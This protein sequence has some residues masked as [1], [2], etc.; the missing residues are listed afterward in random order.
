MKGSDAAISQ[1]ADPPL[2]PLIY[3][4]YH[5]T[6]KKFTYTRFR[7]LPIVFLTRPLVPS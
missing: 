5:Q 7:N 4:Q 1:G 3:S 6:C 2:N